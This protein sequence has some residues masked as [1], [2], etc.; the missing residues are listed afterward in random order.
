[1]KLASQVLKKCEIVEC[2]LIGETEIYSEDAVANYARVFCHYARYDF[3]HRLSHGP[4]PGDFSCR[5]YPSPSLALEFMDEWSEGNGNCNYRCWKIMM[6]HFHSSGCTKYAWEA[7]HLQF[8]LVTLPPPIAYQLK[9][10]IFMNTHGGPGNIPCDLHNEHL[11]K[12]FEEIVSNIGANMSEAAITRA[13]RSVTILQELSTRFDQVTGVPVTRGAHSIID[14][15]NSV[16]SIIMKK[17]IL[18]TRKGRSHA[19]F[20]KFSSNPLPS[21]NKDI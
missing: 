13:A 11:N 1:M 14:D 15:T 16:V 18:E 17:K 8:Q 3:I 9:W 12:L 2:A 6:L 4:A 21:L 20:K 7:L 10:A 5:V 19:T